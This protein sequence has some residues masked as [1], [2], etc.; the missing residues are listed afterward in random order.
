MAHLKSEKDLM[1]RV[2]QML[3]AGVP[4]DAVSGV[5]I[6]DGWGG[7]NGYWVYLNKGWI[8]PAMECHTIHEDT[9]RQLKMMVAS[10]ERWEDD[11]A[12]EV[13]R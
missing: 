10:I 6:E 2:V 3:P 5:E 9:L 8:C 11:P 12:L 13:R 1:D 4:A 7:F